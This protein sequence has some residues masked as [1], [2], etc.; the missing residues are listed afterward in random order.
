MKVFI[1]WS[2]ARSYAVAEALNEWLQLVMQNVQPFFSP[3]MDKGIRWAREID[4]ALEGS[5]FGIVCLTPDNLRSTWIHYETGAVAKTA[6]AKVFT[7]LH[8]VSWTE[9][10][11]PLSAFNHTVAKKDDVFKL[12]K[13]INAQFPEVD[14][15]SL[16]PEILSQA[17]DT[18]W[19]KLETALL[20]AESISEGPT[21]VVETRRDQYEL[22]EEA[23]G[24]LRNLERSSILN[25]GATADEPKGGGIFKVLRVGQ[26]D[27]PLYNQIVISLATDLDENELFDRVKNAI[28]VV[29]HPQGPMEIVA[30][31]TEDGLLIFTVRLGR[32]IT[33]RMVAAMRHV[34]TGN[35]AGLVTDIEFAMT[36]PE[37]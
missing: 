36:P 22:I 5:R 7:F 11:P 4:A 12:V 8:G 19:P 35:L 17:F 6:N 2:G 14:L 10:G 29:Y 24:I 1:S 23:L 31:K 28:L 18:N 16:R 26:R 25:R 30:R 15:P 20:D 37:D 33:A 3:E 21:A 9:V 34:L 32:R 27:E 13:T